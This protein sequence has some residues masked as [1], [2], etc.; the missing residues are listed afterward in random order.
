MASAAAPHDHAGENHAQMRKLRRAVHWAGGSRSPGCYVNTV[1]GVDRQAGAD[2]KLSPAPLDTRRRPLRD[3][4]ISVTDRCNF[5][6]S[7]C[8]PRSVFG[9][10]FRFL[11]HADILT[12][13]EVQRL[14][15]AFVSLGVQKLRLTGGEP[16][17]RRD[18]PE[19][20]RMLRQDGV[21]LALT[22][23]GSLLADKARALAS[24]GLQRV[25]VSL[26]SLDDAV[27]QRMND[28]H[29]PVR[30]VLDGI[31]AAADAGLELK[32]NAV[33]RR[34]VND[35]GLLDLVSYFK[36]SGHVLRLIEFMDVGSTNGW[37]MK[38]VLSAREMLELVRSRHALEHVDAHYR[39]EVAQRWRF[40]DGAGEL[41]IIASVTE[42][43]CGDCSRGRLSAHGSFYTCLFASEGT[44]LRG[45]LR[46]GASDEELCTLIAGIWRKRSDAYSETRGYIPPRRLVRKIEMSYIGG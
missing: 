10:G 36:G 22:T 16:L 25:T 4:R 6:C 42:P 43:F 26:D 30:Q 40:A 23:N 35:A 24:A 32:I 14:A 46:A 41:G 39:G 8:M 11:P 31:R 20:V 34:G 17:L 21:D 3:L 28:A 29:V 19:L 15:R 45:P 2:P 33:I 37:N 44:D 27:F 18:L 7:Y 1:T 12:F 9:P 5:R 13:E 38:E